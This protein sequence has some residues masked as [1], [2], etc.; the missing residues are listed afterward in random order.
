MLL[1]HQP[2]SES[3]EILKMKTVDIIITLKGKIIIFSVSPRLSSMSQIFN[4]A[5]HVLTAGRSQTGF[6]LLYLRLVK[7]EINLMIV[8]DAIKLESVWP[9]T[10]TWA[11]LAEGVRTTIKK[12]S[13]LE[14]VS[15]CWTGA[16]RIQL[17]FGLPLP[18]SGSPVDKKSFLEI[19]RKIE[20]SNNYLNCLQWE[21]TEYLFLN[22]STKTNIRFLCNMSCLGRIVGE[23]GVQGRG[24]QGL[25]GVCGDDDPVRRVLDKVALV[26]RVRVA[27]HQVTGMRA[28]RENCVTKS[29]KYNGPT[30]DYCNEVDVI[31]LVWSLA[32]STGLGV[33]SVKPLLTCGQD[34]HKLSKVMIIPTIEAELGVGEAGVVGGG[35]V[36]HVWVRGE[37]HLDVGVPSA[38]AGLIRVGHEVIIETGLKTLDNADVGTKFLQT[39]SMKGSGG[40]NHPGMGCLA[41]NDSLKWH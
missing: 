23:P 39:V 2:N 1:Q 5:R 6:Y 8:S 25:Q 7:P 17:D 36:R 32:D 34:R 11:D 4:P 21:E 10:V 37:G 18:N 28:A 26:V 9:H 24:D 38:H 33:A 31:V 30:W 40:S 35:G 13:S 27:V 22:L 19:T 14:N 29:N 15:L 3:F 20:F 12:K 16:W 41:T